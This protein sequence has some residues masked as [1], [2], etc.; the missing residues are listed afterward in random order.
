MLET[1][2]ILPQEYYLKHTL[3]HALSVHKNGFNGFCL[4]FFIHFLIKSSISAL[5]KKC[6]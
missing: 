3:R 5:F 1:Q 6:Y 2:G 4:A